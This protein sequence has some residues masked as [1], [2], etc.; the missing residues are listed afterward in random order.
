MLELLAAM[1]DELRIL[2]DEDSFEDEDSTELDDV[3]ASLMSVVP[4][5]L[6]LSPQAH[7]MRDVKS[8]RQCFF[9]IGNNVF[10]G[11]MPSDRELISYSI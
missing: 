8:K 5:V 1:L 3:S 6:S 7:R 2:L 11:W 4:L 9:I 10:W